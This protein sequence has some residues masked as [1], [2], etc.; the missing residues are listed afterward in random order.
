MAVVPTRYFIYD[1]DIYCEYDGAY[2]DYRECSKEEYTEC[3]EKNPYAFEHVERHTIF[4]N[5]VSQ[6]CYTLREE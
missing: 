4:Q 2:G 1:E 3:K 5:G 6:V